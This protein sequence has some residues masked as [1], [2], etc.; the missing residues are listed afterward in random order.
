[1]VVRGRDGVITHAAGLTLVDTHTWSVETL[2][3][4]ATTATVAGGTLLASAEGHDLTAIG[5]GYDLDGAERFHLFGAR[6]I[7]VLE[8]LDER[9]FVDDGA[10]THAVNVRTGRI[11]RRLSRNLPQLLVGSTQRS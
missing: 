11:V 2:H 9:V 3:R 5:L 1:M 7:S 10:S 6:G 4:D 8:R